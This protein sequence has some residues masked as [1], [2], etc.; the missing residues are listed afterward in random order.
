MKIMIVGGGKVGAYLAAFLLK[1]GYEV[2]L[3]EMRKEEIPQLLRDLPADVVVHGN[4]TDPTVL[5]A[6]GIHTVDVLAPVTGVDEVNLVIANLARFEFDVP[7][8]IARVNHPK[9]VWM[10]TPEM[11]VDVALNQADLLGSLIVEEMSLGDMMTLLKLRKGQF[12][13]VVEKVAPTAKAIGMKLKDMNLPNQCVI[14]AV[15]RDGE[16]FVPHGE[17]ILQEMDEIIALVR[18]DQKKQLAIFLDK[19]AL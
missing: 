16:L 4:G 5:E 8:I 12:S 17:A 3:I 1:E 9:N 10:F 7:R 11:G 15:I 14:A 19:Q 2:K 6:A 18:T 13:L